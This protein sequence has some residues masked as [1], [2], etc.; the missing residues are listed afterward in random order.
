[1]PQN[2]IMYSKEEAKQIREEFWDGFKRYSGS[3][4][5]K[6]GFPKKWMLDRTGIKPVNLKFEVGRDYA[7][8]S[9]DIKTSNEQ[10]RMEYYE[11]FESLKTIL[12]EKCP[13]PIHW[14]LVH[15]DEFTKEF[16]RIFCRLENVNIYRRDDWY[17]IYRFLYKSMIV[18][19]EVFIDYKEFIAD[20]N[21]D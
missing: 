21:I 11:K 16:S 19:E 15:S 18:F 13:F 3:R 10:K 12:S 5:R 2:I 1:M 20:I 9:I 8:S 7:L 14:D 4:R 17:P 6:L